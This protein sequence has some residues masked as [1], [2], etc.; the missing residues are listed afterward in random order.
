MK[1]QQQLKK[2]WFLI[3]QSQLMGKVSLWHSLR[4]HFDFLEKDLNEFFALL[5]LSLT[6]FCGFVTFHS[7]LILAI[8]TR[9]ELQNREQSFS[10]SM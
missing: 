8:I 6:N 1:I 2:Y 7:N 5:I 4:G 9:H 3:N 10:E